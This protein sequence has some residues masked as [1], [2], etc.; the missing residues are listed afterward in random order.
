M[1]IGFDAKRAFLNTSGLG[2]YSRSVVESLCKYFPQ[3]EYL[4]FTPRISD[5]FLPDKSECNATVATPQGIWKTFHSVWRSSKIISDLKKHKIELYHGLS[6]E[7]PFGI[8]KSGIKS[9]VTI[10][11]L[12]FLRHPEFYSAADRNIYHRKSKRACA[13]A[14]HIIAVSEQTKED[15]MRFF[16]T[17]EEKISVIYQAIQPI[18]FEEKRSDELIKAQKKFDLSG[19]FILYVGTIEE[20]KN[21]LALLKACQLIPANEEIDLFVV[22]KTTA[23]QK[24]VSEFLLRNWKNH[25]ITFLTSVSTEDLLML[26]QCATMLVYPSKFEGF[27]LPI[28]EALAS[29]IPVIANDEKIFHEAGGRYSE[30]VDVNDAQKFSAAILNVLR[31]DDRRTQMIA[32][33]RIHASKFHPQ[34]QAGALAALYE[35]VQ[36]A[37]FKT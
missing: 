16:G 34:N 29:G 10:H 8:K 32:E 2:N 27:G 19:K 31:N 11:D 3:H 35:L 6:N 37:G 5:L 21:L 7:L 1:K 24:K 28:A 4:L 13:E 12:I 25:G 20:R 26:Y 36:D 23:Y 22:G 14:D 30:Y 33:G 9:V 15:I 18:F 17:A